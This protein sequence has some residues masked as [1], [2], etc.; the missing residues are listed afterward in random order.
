MGY[1]VFLTLSPE[2]R[3]RV[4]TFFT[5][6]HDLYLELDNHP[7]IK[8]IAFVMGDVAYGYRN[9]SRPVFGINYGGGGS[10]THMAFAVMSLI[11]KKFGR[12][13]F[14]YDAHDKLPVEDPWWEVGWRERLKWNRWE[15]IEYFF[16]RR[17]IFRPV[18]AYL[19]KLNE[20]WDQHFNPPTNGTT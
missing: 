3:A 19:K 8:G 11:A 4:Q 14:V 15:I 20:R 7:G 5:V 12:T 17:I 1:S 9:K 16:G 13:E 6:H 18:S 10:P 2:E